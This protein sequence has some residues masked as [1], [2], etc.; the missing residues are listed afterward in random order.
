M[1]S[2][3]GVS[4]PP[5]GGFRACF[6][7]AT[8]F[9]GV[10]LALV[11]QAG[12]ARAAGLNDTGIDFCSNYYSTIPTS[13][14]TVANDGG[15]YTRQD[16]SYGRDEQAAGGHL[17]K[18]GGGSKGFDFTKIA[19]NGGV[20]PASTALG[21]GAADWACT[22]DNVTGLTW[23]VKSASGLRG[24]NHLY[25]WYNS[26]NATNGG[27][28][29]YPDVGGIVINPGGSICLTKNRCDT[30]KYVQDVNATALCAASDWRLPTV[31]ELEGIVDFGSVNPTIDLE[32]FPNTPSSPFWSSSPTAYPVDH[33][34]SVEFYDGIAAYTPNA[35]ALPVRLVRGAP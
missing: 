1:P 32:Y 35:Y 10:L 34:W 7:H 26:N 22:R 6:L 23:E 29:G 21:N 9:Y 2:H 17:T 11:L 16:G 13:C 18:V 14:A 12:A 27:Y 3:D 8:V 25:G 5:N 33:A 24:Q 31:K 30:E 4:C 19:N 20:L 15:T 28:P